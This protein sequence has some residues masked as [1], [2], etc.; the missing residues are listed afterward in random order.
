MPC[1]D[2]FHQVQVDVD[3]GVASLRIKQ[4]GGFGKIS[5]VEAGRVS[6][7][8]LNFLPCHVLEGLAIRVPGMESLESIEQVQ[9][10]VR[11]D[12]SEQ[13]GSVPLIDAEFR[14][15]AG[16]VLPVESLYLKMQ[17]VAAN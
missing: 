15:V 5:G 7:L 3:Q 2:G 10:A 17:E 16:D 11:G 13:H 14:K 1:P 8:L 9:S 4:G 12:L 6:E